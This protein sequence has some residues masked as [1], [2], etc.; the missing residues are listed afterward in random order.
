[1]ACSPECFQ[2][3]MNRIEKSRTPVVEKV[4]TENNENIGISKV[5]SRKKKITDSETN[6]ENI[7]I[8]N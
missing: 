1:M 2:E 3:Y 4:E 8:E 7:I 6:S 5:K